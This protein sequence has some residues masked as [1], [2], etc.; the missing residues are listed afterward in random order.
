MNSFWYKSYDLVKLRQRVTAATAERFGCC[1]G[2][3][4]LDAM[5]VVGKV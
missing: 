4:Q 3:T 5:R 2:P 1:S